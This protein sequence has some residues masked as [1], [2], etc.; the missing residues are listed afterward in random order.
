[1]PTT[2]RLKGFGWIDSH[3]HL[4]DVNQPEASWAQAASKGIRGCL[5][6]GTHPDQWPELKALASEQC[7]IALGTHPWFVRNV[8]QEV[9]ALRLALSEQST[10]VVGEIGLDFCRGRQPRPEPALQLS[11][12]EQQL[13]LASEFNKPVILHAVKAHQEIIVQLKQHP[14]VTGVVHAFNGP[15]PLALQYL[16]QGFYLGIGPQVIRSSKLQETVR[17]MPL[18]RILLETDAPYMAIDK[19]IANPLLDLLTVAERVAELRGL[20]L[21]ALQ[22]QVYENTACCFRW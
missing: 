20:S 10:N 13:T 4:N 17:S 12:F 11:I 22:A 16:K 8:E 18:D 5:I 2:E 7:R 15:D 19:A 6:P 21:T 9:E 14:E 1:M 3:C